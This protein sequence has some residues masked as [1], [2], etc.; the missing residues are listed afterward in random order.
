MF[1]VFS[2]NGIPRF[3]L[4]RGGPRGNGGEEGNYENKLNTYYS[5]LNYQDKE[6]SQ[7]ALG[8]LVGEIGREI[9]LIS[10]GDID[11]PGE[12]NRGLISKVI[13]WI[14]QIKLVIIAFGI[15]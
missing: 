4:G 3:R 15:F 9:D 6:I 7:S 8:E 10:A 12:E 11:K 2:E 1:K 5:S 14:E 13:Q